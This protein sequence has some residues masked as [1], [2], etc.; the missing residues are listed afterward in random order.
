MKKNYKTLQN[1]AYIMKHTFHWQK[2]LLPI[3]MI[4]SIAD[5]CLSF[6]WPLLSSIIIMQVMANV[7]WRQLL[8]T[9]LIATLI[10]GI[11]MLTNTYMRSQTWWRFISA[12]MKFISWRVEK[13]LVMDYEKLEQ[14]DMLD[15]SNKASA[16]TGGNNNGVE[17]MMHSTLQTSMNFMKII[18]SVGIILTLSP[19]LILF[20]ILLSYFH[21]LL[22]DR[23]KKMDKKLT[24]DPLSPYHRKID[25]LNRTTRDFSYAKDIRIFSMKD[26]LFQKQTDIHHEAH[27]KI[28]QS[29]N[30]WMKCD[31]L[32]QVIGLVQEALLYTWIIVGVLRQQLT[33][34]EAILYLGVARNF[35]STLSAILDSIADIRLQSEEI[36][37][38]RTFLEYPDQESDLSTELPL[39]I[40]VVASYEF[41]FENVTFTYKGQSE[42][43]LSHL[44]LTIKPSQRLA[45]VGLNGAG[46]TT[47]VKLLCRLYEPTEGRI[48]MNGIDIRRFDKSAYHHL[49][50]AV[51]QN[52]EV[53][54]FPI[55]ENISMSTP[56]L[57]DYQK[58]DLCLELAG[59]KEK[60]MTLPNGAKT[61]LLKV[62]YDDGIDLSGGEKQKLALSRS[63][64]K[65]APIIILDEPTAALDALAE[66][67]LYSDFDQLIGHKSAVYISHRLSSTRF[68][69]VIAL[70]SNKSLAEY[71]SHECLMAKD[72]LYAEMFRVQAQYYQSE[73]LTFEVEEVLLDA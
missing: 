22:F 56:N 51:F 29:K 12:R 10:Q 21:F 18:A 57:T 6:L 37:D 34:A 38:F 54:A 47:F 64:Y 4:H 71:G 60:I 45:I 62:L 48:L 1:M 32:N 50:A 14:P 25:Y 40:P 23:T 33:L 72:G 36:N 63:L 5:A 58:V 42:P 15:I 53:F 35:A 8:M 52:I 19:V 41:K 20:L 67:K 46:K 26:W 13:V 28:R 55:A 69:D 61:Q 3:M 11:L 39:P 17:G 31:A 24:W 30:R 7:P 65:D 66:Y 59:L 49:F 68:C 16:A 2:P 44:N 43:A 73:D 27:Q 70:F 9:I